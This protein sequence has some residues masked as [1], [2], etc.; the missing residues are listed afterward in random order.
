[1]DAQTITEQ[2]LKLEPEARA[3]IAEILIESLD[4]EEDL[5]VSEEWRQEI[6][7]RCKEIDANSALL[8]DGEQVMAE[9]RQRFL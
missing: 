8:L 9:L 7:K 2:A 1:M 5:P 3:Y 4:Y 6:E